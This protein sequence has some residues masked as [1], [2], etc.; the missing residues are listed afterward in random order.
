M[1]KNS[2][3]DVITNSSAVTYTWIVDGAVENTYKYLQK[4]LDMA[5]L[6]AS[7]RDLYDVEIEVSKEYIYDQYIGYSGSDE[8]E[9]FLSVLSLSAEDVDTKNYDNETVKDFIEFMRGR[10]NLDDVDNEY[11]DTNK[12]LIV[13]SKKTGE[14]LDMGEMAFTLYNVE[15]GYD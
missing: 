7:A 2:M 8:W 4:L 11:G 6:Q 1:R 14:R 10:I 3:V 9:N 15:A 13:T 5:G 12:A